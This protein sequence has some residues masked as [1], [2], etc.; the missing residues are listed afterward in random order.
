MQAEENPWDAPTPHTTHSPVPID[1]ESW[2]ADEKETVSTHSFDNDTPPMDSF[3]DTTPPM[4][5]FDQE[6]TPPMDSFDDE[7]D[8]GEMGGDDDFG[9]F[10]ETDYIPE[11]STSKSVYALMKL[12]L[13]RATAASL[14]PQLT[15]F[16][17][18][19]YPTAADW[20]TDE[21][22]RQVDGVGQ[23]LVTESLS[24]ASLFP[25]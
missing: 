21:Q 1:H 8:F 18:E 24:V 4:D 16:I 25:F 3:D 15:P 13:H 6:I 12:D 11:A 17:Q 20:L 7:D 9:D 23:V 10:E 19:L 22:E 14:E 5:S 2:S